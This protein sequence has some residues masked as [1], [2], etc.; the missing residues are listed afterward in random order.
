MLKTDDIPAH[1]AVNTIRF[2][3]WFPEHE[4]RV[5]SPEFA[6][7][8]KQLLEVENRG[9]WICGTRD[10]LEIHHCH[11]EWSLKNA[12][13][14]N[15]FIIAYPDFGVKYKSLDNFVDSMDNALVL[16]QAH[17]RLA[18]RGIHFLPYPVWEIQ[19]YEIEVP[20]C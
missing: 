13:D 20:K 11:I 15:K 8:R 18:G 2:K 17:H 19:K 1:W 16:C 7:T 4:R 10:Q 5:E 3:T 12:V 6:Q 14:W 9:C